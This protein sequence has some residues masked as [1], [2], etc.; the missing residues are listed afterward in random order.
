MCSLLQAC[1]PVLCL[2]VAPHKCNNAIVDKVSQPT[3]TENGCDILLY[4]V[5]YSARSCYI[6]QEKQVYELI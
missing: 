6:S 3:A 4:G 5:L 2:R 1:F